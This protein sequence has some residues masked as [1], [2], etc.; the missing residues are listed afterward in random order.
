MNIDGNGLRYN[1]GK[2]EFHTIPPQIL[3]ELARLCTYGEIKYPPTEN[4][5]NWTRGMSYNFVL[6]SLERHLLRFKAGESYDKEL[7]VHHMAQVMWNAMAL[8]WYDL[9]PEYKQFDDRPYKEYGVNLYLDEDTI[10]KLNS[11]RHDFNKI[12]T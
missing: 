7:A 12:G 8:M 4:Q 6:N 10:T 1:S 11:Y 5:A 3:A 2:A 9:N